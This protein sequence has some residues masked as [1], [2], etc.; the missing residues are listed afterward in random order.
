MATPAGRIL[1]ADIV[2]PGAGEMIHLWTLAVKERLKIGAVTSMI[3]P[4]PTFS[5]V[6]NCAIS[7]FLAPRLFN[8]G[9]RRLVRLLARLG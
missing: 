2:G 3:V 6:G 4:Y 1:G 5:E 8:D 7:N 9:K